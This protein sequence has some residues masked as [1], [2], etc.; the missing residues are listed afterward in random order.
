MRTPKTLERQKKKYEVR[1]AEETRKPF[2][3]SRGTYWQTSKNQKNARAPPVLRETTCVSR[4]ERNQEEHK[5][6]LRV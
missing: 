4:T 6:K 3:K 2:V 5:G 1:Q